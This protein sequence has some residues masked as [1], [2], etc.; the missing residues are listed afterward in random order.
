MP[1]FQ[2]YWGKP[3]VRTDRGDPGDVGI[4]R[5]PVRASI[6]PDCGGRPVMDVPLSLRLP[7]EAGRSS[8]GRK[9]SCAPETPAL[10]RRVRRPARRLRPTTLVFRN[11][12]GGQARRP[13][14]GSSSPSPLP[15]LAPGPRSPQEASQR[16]ARPPAGR[17]TR[18]PPSTRRSPREIS[19]R[20]Q[21]NPALTGRLN[22]P[23]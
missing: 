19:L 7:R 13:G 3:A 14:D 1:S 4:I 5:S 22:G 21:S 16:G 11:R 2:P 17:M 23:D 8:N 12:R 9:Q 6:L 18:P 15:R 20:A 10:R